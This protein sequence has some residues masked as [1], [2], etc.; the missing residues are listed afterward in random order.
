MSALLPTV[1]ASARRGLARAAAGGP[2]AAPGGT[3]S[4]ASHA[5]PEVTWAQYRSNDATF[6]EWVEANRHIVSLVCLGT[7]GGLIGLSMRGGKK[8]DKADRSVRSRGGTDGRCGGEEVERRCGPAGE[9]GSGG[10][11]PCVGG[12]QPVR[13]G[14]RR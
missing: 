11:G 9:Q 10:G 2:R 12:S 14:E 13:P 6:Q 5:E 1:A 7:F 8:E 4:M 3:R